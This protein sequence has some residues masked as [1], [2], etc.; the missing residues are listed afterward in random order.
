[1]SVVRRIFML[2]GN[3]NIEEIKNFDTELTPMENVLNVLFNRNKYI[4]KDEEIF[5][6]SGLSIL[7][8]DDNVRYLNIIEPNPYRKEH[9]KKSRGLFDIC[10]EINGIH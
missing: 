7:V 9:I 8:F 1:M 5:I 6:R 4:S 2:T 10:V 3:V